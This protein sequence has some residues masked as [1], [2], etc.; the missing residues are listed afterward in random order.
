V[1]C[2]MTGYVIWGQAWR[3]HAPCAWIFLSFFS[4]SVPFVYYESLL[5]Q[6]FYSTYTTGIGDYYKMTY[7][8][9]EQVTAYEMTMVRRQEGRRAKAAGTYV[10][11]D[12]KISMSGIS[13]KS[14][15][16]GHPRTEKLV[17]PREV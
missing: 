7:L 16:T 9:D 14:R 2:V 1:L 8:D 15:E 4:Y 10:I 12:W 3:L 5:V 17:I 6:S 13:G 11:A